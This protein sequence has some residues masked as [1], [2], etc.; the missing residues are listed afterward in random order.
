LWAVVL[1]LLLLMMMMIIII[2]IQAS[3]KIGVILDPHESNH[4]L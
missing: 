2:I 1:L 4:I 3:C